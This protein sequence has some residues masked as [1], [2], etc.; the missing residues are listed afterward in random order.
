MRMEA[1]G[2]WRDDFWGRWDGFVHQEECYA[3]HESC[4]PT[5]DDFVCA[6]EPGGGVG[7]TDGD[8]VQRFEKEDESGVQAN[9]EEE[10]AG[11]FEEEGE[12]DADQGEIEEGG[13][14][15]G[16]VGEAAE[17]LRQDNEAGSG[18]HAT[19]VFRAIEEMQECVEHA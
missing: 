10:G 17:H 6:P 9:G 1:R 11:A 2:S 3:E 16:E 14:H 12:Q 5:V 15:R 13:N 4:G 18:V 7:R 19:G 8:E